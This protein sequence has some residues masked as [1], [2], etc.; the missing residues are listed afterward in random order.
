LTL[1][2]GFDAFRAQAVQTSG[3]ARTFACFNRTA[4]LVIDLSPALFEPRCP[5]QTIT[6]NT[7]SVAAKWFYDLD[8]GVSLLKQLVFRG[9]ASLDQTKSAKRSSVPTVTFGYAV[10]LV[11]S[12]VKEFRKTSLQTPSSQ[13]H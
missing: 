7:F 1:S 12:S 11:V 6:V 5:G 2:G 3:C 9:Q 4:V 8:S 10:G 13:V